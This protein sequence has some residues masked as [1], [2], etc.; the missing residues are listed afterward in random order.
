MKFQK[1]LSKSFKGDHSQNLYPY[2][3]KTEVDYQDEVFLK[4]KLLLN[5]PK[6]HK[7]VLNTNRI[8][9]KYHTVGKY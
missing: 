6:S 7:P 9:R 2:V 1:T 8:L 4:K 5:L 3:W